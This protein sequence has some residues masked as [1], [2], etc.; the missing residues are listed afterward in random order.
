MT[1]S[2]LAG[3]ANAASV[4]GKYSIA[5]LSNLPLVSTRLESVMKH[6]N[7]IDS[8]VGKR[9]QQLRLVRGMDLPGLSSLIGVSAPRLLQFEEGRERIS[10]DLMR[11]LSKILNVSPSEF[12]SGFSRSGANGVGDVAENRAFGRAQEEEQRLLRDFAR[13]RDAKNRELILVLVA[14]YAEFS[15]LDESRTPSGH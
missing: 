12:F 1:G 7:A 15:D 10:A 2:E 11:R 5:D 4:K 3:I 8:H 6:P 14:A 13:V 9:L